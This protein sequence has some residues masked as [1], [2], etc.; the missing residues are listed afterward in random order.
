M[1]NTVQLCRTIIV[2]VQRNSGCHYH[3]TKTEVTS[4]IKFP[5]QSSDFLETVKTFEFNFCRT[6]F[7]KLQDKLNMMRPILVTILCL[8]AGA[9]SETG[10]CRR[11]DQSE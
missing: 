3:G 2:A 10:V 6:L 7:F 1:K 11:E 8:V 4:K 9:Q 5:Q